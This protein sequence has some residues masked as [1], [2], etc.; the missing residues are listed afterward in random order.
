MVF[1]LV[2]VIAGTNTNNPAPVLMHVGNYTS[3][4]ECQ[5]AAKG[6]SYPVRS[7]TNMPQ[8]FRQLAEIE[9]SDEDKTLWL[10]RAADWDRLAAEADKRAKAIASRRAG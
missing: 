10:Q 1:W 7:L 3:S 8:A 9:A 4:S 2:L 5:T 6:A